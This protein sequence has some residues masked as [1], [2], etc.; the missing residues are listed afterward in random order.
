MYV[1]LYIDNIHS[2]HSMY[3]LTFIFN[4]INRFT[5]LNILFTKSEKKLEN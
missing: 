4:A 1:Y 5:A 2:T 3:T